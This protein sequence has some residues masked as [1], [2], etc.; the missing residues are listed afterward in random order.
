M[1]PWCQRRCCVCLSMQRTFTNTWERVKCEIIHL[2]SC[3]DTVRC[4][5]ANRKLLHCTWLLFLMPDEVEAKATLLGEPPRD[6]QRHAGHPGGLVGGGCP[7]IQASLWNAAPCRQL[8]GPLS[9][10]HNTC[11]TGK[12][13]ASWHSCITNCCVSFQRYDTF[14]VLPLQKN[15]T[16]PDLWLVE[17][18]RRSTLL[19]WMSLCTLQTAPTLGSSWSTWSIFSWKFWLSRWQ[20]PPQTSFF[21]FSCPC[22]L[23]VLSQRTSPWWAKSISKMTAR[24]CLDLCSRC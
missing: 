17:N 10:L 5:L 6:H 14:P 12:A 21:T 3:P 15:V 1:R 13:A 22:T 23:S 4:I 16:P 20:P 8:F 18:M 24:L 7:G 2:I 19:S 11:E 9:V